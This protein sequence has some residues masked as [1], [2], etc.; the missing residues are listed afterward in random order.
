M[1]SKL[2]VAPIRIEISDTETGPW[3]VLDTAQTEAQAQDK[4]R[5]HKISAV[6][7]TRIVPNDPLVS[8]V[9]VSVVD[10]AET[11]RLIEEYG[12]E[13][14]TLRRENVALRLENEKISAM[15]NPPAPID[16]LVG[17]TAAP[18]QVGQTLRDVHTGVAVRVTHADEPHWQIGNKARGFKWI[19]LTT[20]EGD[21]DHTGFCPFESAGCFAVIKDSDPVKTEP[22]GQQVTQEETAAAVAKPAAA[23]PAHHA[24]PHHAPAHHAPAHKAAKRKPAKHK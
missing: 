23:K 6:L 22:T 8:D 21:K 9:P 15:K 12:I 4:L 3:L 14:Q 20:K 1:H 2:F 10:T 16:A 18:F 24:P 5:R 17:A 19:N 11:K 13:N 7:E